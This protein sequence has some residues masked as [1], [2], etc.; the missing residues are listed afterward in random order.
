[1]RPRPRRV[2]GQRQKE[3]PKNNRY[4]GRRRRGR[5]FRPP[6][7]G[8]DFAAAIPVLQHGPRDAVTNSVAERFRRLDVARFQKSV[9]SLLR[10]PHEARRL[11]CRYFVSCC[12]FDLFRLSALKAVLTALETNR[13]RGIPS[14]A[15]L[16]L[17]YS[18]SSVGRLTLVFI[19]AHCMV[20]LVLLVIPL[21]QEKVFGEIK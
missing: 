13:D 8:R 12:H 6:V 4:C 20:I 19:N 18:M 9:D 11:R 16:V 15:D 3:N 7:R 10:Y 14:T 2:L 17:K 5:S 1:M 21:W